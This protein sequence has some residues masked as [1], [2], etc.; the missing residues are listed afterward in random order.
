MSVLTMSPQTT[1]TQ[2]W[3]A[4]PLGQAQ[5]QAA[6][7]REAVEPGRLGSHGPP[8]W[9]VYVTFGKL[10]NHDGP[11]LTGLYDEGDITHSKKLLLFRR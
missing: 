5:C 8:L 1:T 10:C 6:S 3:P 2:T 9:T 4:V 11:Q 7:R